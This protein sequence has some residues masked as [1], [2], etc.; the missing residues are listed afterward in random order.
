MKI[1]QPLKKPLKNTGLILKAILLISLFFITPARIYPAYLINPYYL[2]RTAALAQDSS[3]MFFNSAGLGL[4]QDMNAYLNLAYAESENK[5]LSLAFN[6]FAGGLAY[7]NYTVTNKEYTVYHY[8]LPGQINLLGIDFNIGIH[9]KWYNINGSHPYTIGIGFLTRFL[10]HFSLGMVFD[11]LNCEKIYTDDSAYP[12][13]KYSLAVGFFKNR[14]IFSVENIAREEL[15]Y[16]NNI[17]Y[18]SI[19]LIRGLPF[20]ISYFDLK[21]YK[22][23]MLAV[24][25]QFPN[26]GFAFYNFDRQHPKSNNNYEISVNTKRND[27]YFTIRNQVAEINITGLLTDTDQFSWFGDKSQ[28]TQRILTDLD[29]C[30]ED[31]AIRGII[32]T[33]GQIQTTSYGGI[34]GLVYEIR[35]KILQLREK[36]KLIVAYLDTGGSTEEYYLASA[37]NAIVMPPTASLDELGISVKALKLKKTLDR[38]GIG[39]DII[40]SGD[41]K[42]ALNPFSDSINKKQLEKIEKS[43]EDSY[44]LFLKTVSK[45]R[46]I[47]KENIDKLINEYPVLDAELLKQEE[48]IDHIGY[49]SKANNA[50][51]VFLHKREIPAYQKINIQ[52]TEYLQKDWKESPKIAVVYIYGSIVPG[53]SVFNSFDGTLYTGSETIINQLKAINGDPTIKGIILRIDSPGGSVIAC[54][55]I[56]ETLLE[57]KNN[58]K[59]IVASFGSMAAS[60]G[61]YI[62]CGAHEII[63]TPYTLTG[64]IGV[65]TMKLELSGIFKKYDVETPTIKRG[66]YADAN[67][68]DR[69]YTKEEREKIQKAIEKIHNRFKDIVHKS[70]R[71]SYEDLKDIADGSVYTGNQAKGLNLVDRLGGIKMAVQQICKQ[72]DDDD[73][74]I[75]YYW[76]DMRSYSPIKLGS[77]PLYKLFQID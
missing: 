9:N 30:L 16:K 35:E 65:F 13:K 15:L 18:S 26:L 34:G 48:W 63:S 51:A 27:T 36:G 70:R 76:K 2:Y 54:D 29:K 32:I 20:I 75:I 66:K 7:E 31:D 24:K 4:A 60:G 46:L 10:N 73:P 17:Y 33:I 53:Q 5:N 67:G 57:V 3:G 37:A 61:Y 12:L 71:I 74:I 8:V 22:K 64:S 68:Y 6:F 38:F 62:A 55:D 69:Q 59:Y 1:L 23:I 21:D 44:D 49:K 42:N 56:Y 43:V 47:K 77:M 19:E 25:L 72:I 50:M 14:F 41:N 40:Q 11:N 45:S 28:G 39:F 58:G 52:A